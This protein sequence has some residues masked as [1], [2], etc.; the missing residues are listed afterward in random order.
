MSTNNRLNENGVLS[1]M[2]L[3]GSFQVLKKNFCELSLSNNPYISKMGLFLTASKMLIVWHILTC[4]SLQKLETWNIRYSG[5]RCKKK[6]ELQNTLTC[7][8]SSLDL[9][10]LTKQL[11]PYTRLSIVIP[12]H[13]DQYVTP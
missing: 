5:Y 1:I 13:T 2:T 4:I 3:V 6:K 11:A 12:L 8:A 9:P 10:T 7:F